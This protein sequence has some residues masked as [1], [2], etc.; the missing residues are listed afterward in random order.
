MASVQFCGAGGAQN[1]GPG[2]AWRWAAASSEAHLFG[3]AFKWPPGAGRRGMASAGVR[4]GPDGRW[5]M[6]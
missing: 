3:E 4:G 5:K 2:S 1:L 6:L